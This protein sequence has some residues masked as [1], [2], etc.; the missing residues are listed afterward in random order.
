MLSTK[1]YDERGIFC[2]SQKQWGHWR[3]CPEADGSRDEPVP[4]VWHQR[5]SGYWQS[6]QQRHP[7]ITAPSPLPAS[8]HT[9]RLQHVESMCALW[10][11][12]SDRVAA[13]QQAIN[14]PHC[15]ACEWK[16]LKIQR[17][18]RAYIYTGRRAFSSNYAAHTWW[19]T[20]SEL[21]KQHPIR[22]KWQLSLPVLLQAGTLIKTFA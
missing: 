3:C 19:I 4:S 22:S 5:H 6:A 10:A 20:G 8:H 18:Y 12:I 9:K 13:V 21:F 7:K 11:K 17:A 2:L 1:N 15:A 14:G 16:F